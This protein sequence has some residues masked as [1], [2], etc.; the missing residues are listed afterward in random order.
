MPF[1]LSAIYVEANNIYNTIDTHKVELNTYGGKVKAA[2]DNL[3]NRLKDILS[4]DPKYFNKLSCGMSDNLFDV[5]IMGNKISTRSPE[6]VFCI[7][8]LENGSVD[9][10]KLDEYN[11]CLAEILASDEAEDFMTYM[12]EKCYKIEAYECTGLFADTLFMVGSH[13]NNSHDEDWIDRYKEVNKY[14]KEDLGITNDPLAAVEGVTIYEIEN[15][16]NEIWSDTFRDIKLIGE[17]TDINI[18]LNNYDASED[19]FYRKLLGLD[20]S[21]GYLIN[22][23]QTIKIA[24]EDYKNGASIKDIFNKYAGAIPDDVLVNTLEAVSI[25]TT[26]TID[27][28]NSI[29]ELNCEGWETYI[30]DTGAHIPDERGIIFINDQDS[31]NGKDYSMYYGKKN[32]NLEFLE[33]IDESSFD[34]K[35]G[36]IYGEANM[37]EV[38]ATGNA[39]SNH[40]GE[41]AFL[42]DIADDYLKMSPVLDGYGGTSPYSIPVLL[43]EKDIDTVFYYADD[44]SEEK[45]KYLYE[46]CD[47]VIFTAWNGP[48]PYN[49]IHTMYISIEESESSST[50]YFCTRHNDRNGFTEGEDLQILI[51][52]YSK[53]SG[54]A[55]CIIGVMKE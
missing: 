29:Y 18:H 11:A 55:I 43:N 4:V 28:I 53:M 52:D 20:V 25:N 15:L 22:N 49:A 10:N 23:K 47:G 54:G 45:Y 1:S 8:A 40:I 30:N 36:Y 24:Y 38:I 19:A 34:K 2:D 14:L 33:L 3:N 7:N 31:I 42:P 39:I 5:G 21:S 32:D 27:D 12:E 48:N 17:G 50:G 51:E 46:N 37:C 16:R 41:T 6:Y 9:S 44:M 35:N 26:L 13:V